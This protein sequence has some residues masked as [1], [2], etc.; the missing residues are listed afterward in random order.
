MMGMLVGCWP[1][2]VE[3]PSS[4]NRK[5]LR[6]HTNYDSIMRNRKIIVEAAVVTE[7]ELMTIPLLI[8]WNSFHAFPPLN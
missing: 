7:R 5:Y 8:V 4:V 6:I 3:S 2:P 1:S